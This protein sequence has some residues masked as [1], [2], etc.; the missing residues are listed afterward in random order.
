MEQTRTRPDPFGTAVAFA[1]GTLAG[2]LLAAPAFPSGLT[3][4]GQ[5][6]QLG[7]VE[8]AL[9]VAGLSILVVPLGVFVLYVLFA[10]VEN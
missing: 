3:I 10:S 4:P 7:P 8:T 5:T 6:V 1:L 2:L 9:F